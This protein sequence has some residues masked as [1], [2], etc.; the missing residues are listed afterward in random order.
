MIQWLFDCFLVMLAEK[1]LKNRYCFGSKSNISTYNLQK[2]KNALQK[3]IKAANIKKYTNN[4][5]LES[6]SPWN[7]I[8]GSN[9]KII[10]IITPNPRGDN[11][12]K[13]KDWLYLN[14]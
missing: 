1:A 5:N 4:A 6:K 8:L 3:V 14:K 10:F 11:K 12:T 9:K 2:N 13:F 7:E